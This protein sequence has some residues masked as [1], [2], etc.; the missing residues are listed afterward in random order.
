MHIL[1][2]PGVTMPR[3]EEDVLARIREAAGLEAEGIARAEEYL[4]H[5]DLVLWVVDATQPEPESCCP[6]HKL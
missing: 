5:A 6:P 3:V 4:Q 1:I 2:I